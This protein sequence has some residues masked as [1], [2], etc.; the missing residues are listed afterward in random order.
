[1]S[2]V[3]AGVIMEVKQLFER[4]RYRAIWRLL[5]ELGRDAYISE[6][7]LVLMLAAA[8]HY[9]F[10]N[11]RAL[12][13]LTD[14]RD[15]FHESNN[16][17]VVRRWQNLYANEL[18]E[19]GEVNL[20][21]D[22]LQE[23][24]ASAERASHI[25]V[26]GYAAN[27]LGNVFSVKGEVDQAIRYYGRSLAAMQQIGDR[28][29]VGSVHH[30][31]GLVLREWG[32]YGNAAKHFKLADDYFAAEATPEER[33]FTSS[34]RAMLFLEIGDGQ[35]AESLARTAV[36]RANHLSNL[37]LY[38]AAS[39]VLGSIILR[40]R[41]HQEAKP[42]LADAWEAAGRSGRKLLKAETCEE[43]AI[44]EAMAGEMDAAAKYRNLAV[45][46]YVL[47][48]AQK[49]ADRFENRYSTVVPSAARSV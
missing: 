11:G 29:V 49:H 19:S 26:I 3:H 15:Q 41:G 31:M 10:E 38:A 12:Q 33:V 17:S 4:R 23:C 16:E 32:S 44:L 8:W 9:L 21:R 7:E 37:F 48:G 14:V 27:G 22:L 6:P 47:M 39:K 30:N 36:A 45:E 40:R 2:E 1:M 28:Q 13:L 46:C 42:Y 18:L 35:L 43:L 20:A 24:L 5:D 34:E 25:R